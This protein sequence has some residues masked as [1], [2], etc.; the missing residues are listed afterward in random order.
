MV[1]E[2]VVVILLDLVVLEILH[3]L[4]HHKVILE[5]PEGPSTRATAVVAVVEQDLLALILIRLVILL[6]VVVM[7]FRSQQHSRIQ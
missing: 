2:V 5:V 1:P 6:E 7:V 4:Y 3:Q